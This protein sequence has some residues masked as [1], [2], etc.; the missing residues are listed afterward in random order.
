MIR[1][2]DRELAFIADQAEATYIRGSQNFTLDDITVGSAMIL[3]DFRS[4]VLPKGWQPDEAQRV[5]IYRYCGAFL[6]FWDDLLSDEGTTSDDILYYADIREVVI[7]IQ[8]KQMRL[9]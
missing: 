8:R 3:D 6:A 2:T 7:S 4:E 1:F 5:A 9:L